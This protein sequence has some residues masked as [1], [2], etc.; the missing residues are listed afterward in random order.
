MNKK[1]NVL[2]DYFDELYRNPGWYKKPL[3]LTLEEWKEW[4][5]RMKSMYPIQY[6]LREMCS[7]IS[8]NLKHR[9]SDIYYKIR[10]FIK[11]QNDKVRKA[12]PRNWCDITELIVRVNFAMIESFYDEAN[13]SYVDWTHDEGVRNFKA[14]LDEAHQWITVGRKE[15]EEKLDASYPKDVSLVDV[16]PYKELYEKVDYYEKL[17]EDTDTKIIKQAIDYRQYMWT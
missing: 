5:T 8:Y 17:I 2:V 4:E 3:S 11:P 7:S 16:R 14:W 13:T 15:I 9:Y 1:R 10:N 6:R 12:I